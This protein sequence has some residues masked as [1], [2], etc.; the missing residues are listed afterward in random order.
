MFTET[1]QKHKYGQISAAVATLA[2]MIL[3]PYLVHL[4]AP[5]AGVPLGARLLPIFYA[6]LVA[7]F[8]FDWKTAVAASLLA[9]ILNHLITGSPAQGMV[10]LLT[11]EVVVFCLVVALLARR[12]P[13]LFLTGPLAYLT[14]VAAASLTLLIIPL[15]PSPAVAF[16]TTS[17]VNA[18][19]GLLILL[20]INIIL[21]QLIKRRYAA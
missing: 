8:L 14:A 19:P 15:L 4:I 10:L 17:V 7:V 5:T 1:L 20:L 3:L 13:R 2:A 16:F 21:I 12:W 11:I 18:L 9:P 6:P